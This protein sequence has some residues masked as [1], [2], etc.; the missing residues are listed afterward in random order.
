MANVSYD[1]HSLYTD[2]KKLWIGCLHSSKDE[3]SVWEGLLESNTVVVDSSSILPY[4]PQ[5]KK[6][7]FSFAQGSIPEENKK[8]AFYKQYD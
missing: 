3:I 8:L 4:L 7:I 5:S 6:S 1:N 2:V